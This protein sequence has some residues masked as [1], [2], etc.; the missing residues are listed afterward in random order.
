MSNIYSSTATT[1]RRMN[2]A[3]SL[4][5]LNPVRVQL[6]KLS[7]LLPVVESE[8]Y[9]LFVSLLGFQ[10]NLPCPSRRLWIHGGEYSAP[11]QSS[12]YHYRDL[13]SFDLQ[14]HVWERWE[15]KLRPSAR[16]GHRMVVHKNFI[17][18]FGG[19]QDTGAP[20]FPSFFC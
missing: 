16:S 11:N 19:F 10:R 13:W 18:L 5:L 3:G 8:R 20:P 15:T 14:T 6:T 1:R 12:F 7:E 9:S 17:F 2:G 4:L